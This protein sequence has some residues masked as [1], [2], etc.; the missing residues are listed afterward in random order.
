MAPIPL[1]IRV[2]GHEESLL[3]RIGLLLAAEALVKLS[4][5]G[6]SS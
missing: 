4:K 5:L 1:C 6:A 2:A 3:P